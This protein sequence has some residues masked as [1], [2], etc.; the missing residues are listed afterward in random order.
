MQDR[1]I[2]PPCFVV[3]VRIFWEAA[4]IHDA[5]LRTDAWPG[6]WRRFTA[7]VETRPRKPARQPGPGSVEVPPR[8]P[9]L[10]ASSWIDDVV[11][12]Y[13]VT[14]LVC[15]VDAASEHRACCLRADYRLL[16]VILVV[17]I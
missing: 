14:Q 3:E 13:P 6:I 2:P 7:I 16:G 17:L 1:L 9:F 4:H 8:L 11:R 12:T 15:T 5:K 10:N